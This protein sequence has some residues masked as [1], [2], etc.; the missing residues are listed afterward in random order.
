MNIRETAILIQY[1]VDVHRIN[2]KLYIKSET[3]N[4]VDLNVCT[5]IINSLKM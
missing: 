1:L 5:Y 4:K 3:V 2:Y